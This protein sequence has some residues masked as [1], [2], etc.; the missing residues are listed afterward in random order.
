MMHAHPAHAC[1]Q[2]ALEQNGRLLQQAYQFDH[3]AFALLDRPGLDAGRFDR[4]QTLRRKAAERYQE[5]LEHL[6]LIERTFHAP[7]SGARARSP[8][9]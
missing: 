8:R 9:R 4:Y 3:T 2:L 5:A 7:N 1:R 6:A